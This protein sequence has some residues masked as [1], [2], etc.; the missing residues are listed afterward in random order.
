[1]RSSARFYIVCDRASVG[2]QATLPLCRFSMRLP[3]LLC[4]S[5]AS[6]SALSSVYQS[7]VAGRHQVQYNQ[8]EAADSNSLAVVYGAGGSIGSAVAKAF[9]REGATVFLAGRTLT[10]LKPVAP[11]ITAAR[12][13]AHTAQVD[14]LD[15]QAVDRYVHAVVELTGCIDVSFNPIDIAS[16]IQGTPLIE[17]SPETVCLPVMHRVATNFLTARAAARHMV[18]QGAGVI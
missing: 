15:A 9:A 17:L 10:D 12:G 4:G 1:L 6:S 5:I 14:A 7:I 2:A 3:P 8:I 11:E 16:S 13:T 18:K